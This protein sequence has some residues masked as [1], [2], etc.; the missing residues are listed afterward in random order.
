MIASKDHPTYGLIGYHYLPRGKIMC[1]FSKPERPE[2][3]PFDELLPRG[4]AWKEDSEVKVV[5]RYAWPE[6]EMKL[7]ITLECKSVD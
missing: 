5:E 2:E 7:H 6:G 4:W 3:I 1:T